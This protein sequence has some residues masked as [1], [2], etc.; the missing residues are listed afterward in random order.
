MFR[1]LGATLACFFL[2]VFSLLRSASRCRTS[3]R[4]CAEMGEMASWVAAS[5]SRHRL[6]AGPCNRR[7]RPV[8]EAG[9]RPPSWSSPTLLEQQ[10]LKTNVSH[11][12]AKYRARPCPVRIACIAAPAKK[13]SNFAPRVA[14]PRRN[15]ARL[16][17]LSRARVA[18]R[19]QGGAAAPCNPFVPPSPAQPSP[20]PTHHVNNHRRTWRRDPSC[21]PSLE[22]RAITTTNSP[23]KDLDLLGHRCTDRQV[24]P[25][26]SL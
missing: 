13:T 19:P 5:R 18:C 23:S 15:L 4:R 3:H 25:P 20:P 24:F 9:R 11:Q 21:T 1:V 22:P 2:S 17:A 10:P 12:P 8:T 7:Q 6:M 26:F 16:R 14:C